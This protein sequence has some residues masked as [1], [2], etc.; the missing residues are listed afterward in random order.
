M[1]LTSPACC[2]SCGGCHRPLVPQ[3][4]GRVFHLLAWHSHDRLNQ[5]HLFDR[6]FRWWKYCR[7]LPKYCPIPRAH[8]YLQA[9]RGDMV[10]GSCPCG[11]RAQ[12]ASGGDG[13]HEIPEVDF[14][15]PWIH[16]ESHLQQPVA[17]AAACALAAVRDAHWTARLWCC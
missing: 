11:R 6:V 15:P 3:W 16:P 1:T 9:C 8:G 10:P 17:V 12:A 14:F 7:G 5:P 13:R 2:S 4:H